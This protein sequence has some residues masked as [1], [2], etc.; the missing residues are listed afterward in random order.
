MTC[1]P[2]SCAPQKPLPTLTC[3]ETTD[4]DRFP[5]IREVSERHYLRPGAQTNHTIMAFLARG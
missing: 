5:G 4:I 1:L 2:A 3:F